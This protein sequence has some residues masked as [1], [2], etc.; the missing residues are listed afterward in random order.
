MGRAPVAKFAISNLQFSICTTFTSWP[1]PL[2]RLRKPKLYL[3]LMQS[4]NRGGRIRRIQ[5]LRNQKLR[6]VKQ[7]PIIDRQRA[8]ERCLQSKTQ[9][10]R[11]APAHAQV[12]RVH[13]F[14]K[15]AR[16]RDRLWMQNVPDAAKHIAAVIE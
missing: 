12:L 8:A 10:H 13:I 1:C 7:K 14:H 5:V 11:M 6:R 3:S 4:I 15:I 2:K 9:A 16:W